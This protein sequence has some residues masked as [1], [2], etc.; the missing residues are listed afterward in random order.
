VS[1]IFFILLFKGVDEIFLK[2]NMQATRRL[3]TQI[4]ATTVVPGKSEQHLFCHKN[5]NI[6]SFQPKNTSLTPPGTITN[7]SINSKHL[8][9]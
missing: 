7:Q 6:K 1:K 3:R 9:N 5:L 4:P 8:K 2:K